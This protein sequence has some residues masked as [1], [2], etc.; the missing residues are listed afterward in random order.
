MRA[1]T[2]HAGVQHAGVHNLLTLLSN[3]K[4]FTKRWKQH[5]LARLLQP[6]H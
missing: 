5:L 2:D 6:V 1:H 3:L 4:L